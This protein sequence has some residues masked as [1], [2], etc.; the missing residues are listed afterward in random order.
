[1]S[2]F[3]FIRIALV[4]TMTVLAWSSPV[5]AGPH[6]HEEGD[7]R[8]GRMPN[9]QLKLLFT[10][11]LTVLPVIDS[12]PLTGWGLDEPGFFSIDET[13]PEEDMSPLASGNNIVVE[14][15]GSGLDNGLKS[16]L[17]GFGNYLGNGPLSVLSWNL[18]P[19]FTDTHSFWHIDPTTPGFVSPPDQTEWSATIRVI[20]TGSTGYL[21]SDPITLTFAPEPGSLALLVI[22]GALALRR[23][24]RR[25][26]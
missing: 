22:G 6:E 11:G 26:A 8:V 1:M 4:L 23:N 16:W 9:G 20:D 15:V 13:I 7:I 24:H 12:G 10:A 25:Q 2:R 3:S 5:W 21:A 14:V 18:G 17:P 19:D